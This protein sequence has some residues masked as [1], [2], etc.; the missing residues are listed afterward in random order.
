[1]DAVSVR[2]PRISAA[3]EAETYIRGHGGSIFI[4]PSHHRCCGGR[5]TLLET[6]TER[7]SGRDFKEIARGGFIVFLDAS[8][9]ERPEEIELSLRGIHRKR[10]EAYWDGCAFVI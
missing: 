7:P 8:L 10:I 9:R 2:I 1:M 4:W 5:L 6:S 3:P